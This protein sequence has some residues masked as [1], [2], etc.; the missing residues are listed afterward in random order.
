MCKESEFTRELENLI[1]NSDFNAPKTL[2]QAYY[3]YIYEEVYDGTAKTIPHF[4]C[5]VFIESNDA[6]ARTLAIYKNISK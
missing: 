1:Q 3:R 4:G 6:S 5:R 2:E